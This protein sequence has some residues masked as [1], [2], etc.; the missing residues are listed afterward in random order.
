M[1][2]RLSVAVGVTMVI[3]YLM[4]NVDELYK[5]VGR[6]FES[7][8]NYWLNQSGDYSMFARDMFITYAKQYFLEK[9]VIGSGVA[10]FL[11][12]LGADT[13]F[14]AY[15]HNNY[16]ELLVGVGLVGF[17]I[18]YSFYAYLFVKLFKM[19]FKY[20]D[21]IAKVMLTMLI[22][23]IICEYGI[24]LYY[25]VYALIFLCVAYL[26]VCVFDNERVKTSYNQI[27]QINK[28]QLNI[29][30]NAERKGI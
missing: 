11:S 29:S 19:S 21:L 23:I 8:W 6:R 30:E 12:K 7:M 3:L 2:F 5:A 13:G 25:S 15:A 27:V 1:I 24:V 26:Y 16:Y 9:P 10:T 18:Y 20:D 4:M 28:E 17:T 14:Y 22:S